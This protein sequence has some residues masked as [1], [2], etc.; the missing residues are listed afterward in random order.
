M[1][2]Q[3]KKIIA[4]HNSF[5][6]SKR[7][8]HNEL[9]IRF[10]V[11]KLFTQTPLATKYVKIYKQYFYIDHETGNRL[12]RVLRW[13]IPARANTNRG[14]RTTV[15]TQFWSHQQGTTVANELEKTG[16][17]LHEHCNPKWSGR[18]AIKRL[19]GPP[20]KTWFD[21]LIYIQRLFNFKRWCVDL[22]V[23]KIGLDFERT[24]V[25]QRCARF[26]SYTH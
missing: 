20:W 22:V 4:A 23:N 12:A 2:C 25:L 11:K 24:L 14:K 8:R 21:K 3:V 7:K 10:E 17:H 19:F 18:T 16:R 13:P 6:S 9:A 1:K 15:V 26:Q 5:Q